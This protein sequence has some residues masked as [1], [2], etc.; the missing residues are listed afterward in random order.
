MLRSHEAVAE[1]IT[2]LYYISSSVPPIPMSKTILVA[3]DDTF[4]VETIKLSLEEHGAT[5]VVAK[6]GEEAI[7]AMDKKQPDLLLLD[8]LM[9]KVDG[10]GVLQHIKDKEYRFPTVILSNLSVELDRDKCARFGAKD[11]FVKSNMDEDELW[12]KIK[13]YL[14]E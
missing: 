14:G 12:P 7:K 13:K 5:V 1:Y 11:Y 4:L 10:Y 2:I 3:E 8:L 6:N 9:P